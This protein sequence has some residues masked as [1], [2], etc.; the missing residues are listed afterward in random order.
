MAIKENYIPEQGYPRHLA[1]QECMKVRNQRDNA[2]HC[3]ID[4][5]V[6]IFHE[7]VNKGEYN[8]YLSPDTR[9]PIIYIDD[10]F[11]AIIKIM[12]EPNERLKRRVYNINAISFTPNELNHEII[13]HMPH[14]KIS[15][16]IDFRRKIGKLFMIII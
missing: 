6:H 3:F 12:Q 16:N 10:C 8:C 9:L 11:H 15:Y 2:N 1:R 5:A 14:L 4:Y 13:K 7:A